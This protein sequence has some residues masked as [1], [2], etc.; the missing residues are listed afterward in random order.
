M[1][2]TIM[3]VTSLMNLESE[4]KNSIS[5]FSFEFLIMLN[6]DSSF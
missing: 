6:Q 1:V 5:S 3:E 2:R 4:D